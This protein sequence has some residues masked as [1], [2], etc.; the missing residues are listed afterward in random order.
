[1][2]HYNIHEI[3]EYQS[4]LE[5]TKKHLKYVLSSYVLRR[6]QKKKQI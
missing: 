1:M 3:G 5:K 4:K 2:N 6:I